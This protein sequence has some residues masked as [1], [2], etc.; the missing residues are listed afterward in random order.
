MY[1]LK[2]LVAD[3]YIP[4][5]LIIPTIK[6]SIMTSTSIYQ[7]PV[8]SYVYRLDN[9]TTGEFYFGFRKANKVPASKD[10][11]IYYFTSS[12]YVE[13]RFHEFNYTIIQEF[14]D[15]FEAYDL[16]QF[17]IYQ[18]LKNPLMLNRR[19]HYGSKSRFTTAGSKRG[20]QSQEHKAKLS[21]AK[22]GKPSSNRGKPRSEETKAKQSAAR[23]GKKQPNISAAKKGIPI[24]PRS[25]ESNDKL[26]N[27]T[28][29]VSK[30]PQTEEHKAKISA[31]KKGIPQPKFFSIIETKKTYTKP[32]VSRLYPEFKQ[33][34]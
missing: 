20:P 5:A 17:L 9:P 25:K 19:C 27:S 8:L 16:E 31:V 1:K 30:K 34:F 11:G 32:C 26:S 13:P 23:K 24:R 22:K 6:G 15:P 29:G 12:E 18:E 33:Y 4:L 21:A 7:K 28:K 3:S 14:V 2:K 10:L